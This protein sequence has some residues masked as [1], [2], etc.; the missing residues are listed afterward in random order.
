M[1]RRVL[2]AGGLAGVMVVLVGCGRLLPSRTDSLN[3]PVEAFDHVT[4]SEMETSGGGTMRTSLRGDIHFD[5]GQDQL[6][7]ALDLVWRDV[8]EY[9]FELDDGFGMRTVLVI[10]HGAEGATVAPKELLGPEHAD[11]DGA[12]H[13]GDFFEYYGLI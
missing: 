12:A 1:Q 2:L 8:T 10:A 9:V 11:Q 7:E 3:D 5:V 13:F 4:S 6:L